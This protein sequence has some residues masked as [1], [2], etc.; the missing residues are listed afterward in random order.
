MKAY[1]QQ[2]TADDV[3]VGSPLIVVVDVTEVVVD[4]D[5]LFTEAL[6]VVTFVV[7]FVKVVFTVGMNEVVPEPDDV[8]V[9]VSEVA[10]ARIRM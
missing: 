10:E 7:L 2:L 6:M 9:N 8:S 5:V 3:C 1:W 4:A